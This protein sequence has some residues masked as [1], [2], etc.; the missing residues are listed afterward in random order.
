MSVLLV[1]SEQVDPCEHGALRHSST[2][3]SQLPPR[4]MEQSSGIGDTATIELY[5]HAPFANP[6]VQVHEYASIKTVGEEVESV[7]NAPFWQGE[8]AH[9]SVSISHST[10]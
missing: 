1:D 6:A 3:M 7:Q 8:L 10:P 2:S 9:S 5:Q 4:L